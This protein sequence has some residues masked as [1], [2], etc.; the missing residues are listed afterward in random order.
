MFF[1]QQSRDLRV[2]KSPGEIYQRESDVIFIK[3]VE[4]KYGL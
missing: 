3:M 2:S 4:L 1:I